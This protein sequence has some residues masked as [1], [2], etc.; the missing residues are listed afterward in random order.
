MLVQAAEALPEGLFL[1]VIEGYR[2][3]SVQRAMH[4]YTLDRVKKEF[5]EMSDKEIEIEAGKRS[6]PPDAITPPPHLTGGAVDL[7]I[8]DTDGK[9]LDFTSPFSR[10]DWQSASVS[11]EGL[12]D[13]AI[14]NRALLWKI[15]EP[16]GLTSYVDEWWHWS[17]G[18]NGWALRVNAPHALYGK[19]E[20]P[21]RVDWVGDISK[22]HE[23]K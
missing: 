14:A 23:V 10:I 15:L 17:Y 7:D 3:I 13:E 12:S 1:S 16:T 21:E 4:A 2:P 19:I 8:V 20:L 18:D 9:S 22:L 6:A 5:P 11:V